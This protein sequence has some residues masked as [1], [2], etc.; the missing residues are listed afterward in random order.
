MPGAGGSTALTR[1]IRSAPDGYTI[2]IGNSG[3]NAATYTIHKDLPFTPDSFT[4][5]G[6]VARTA[7]LIAVKKDSPYRDAAALIAFA[8][9]NPGKLNFGHAGLGSNNYLICKI[10]FQSAGA[11]VTLVSYRGAAP[12][13][14]DLIGGQID[15]VC[16]NATSV[17]GAVQSGQVHGLVV[18]A[19]ARLPKMPGVPTSE[20]AGI[21]AFQAQGWNAVFAPKGIPAA[22][23]DRLRDALR[24]AL[25]GDLLKRRFSEIETAAAAEG[26]LSPEFLR[27]FIPAEIERFKKLLKE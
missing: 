8:K 9:Q 21:P 11:D 5:V 6:I 26:D 10:F 15:G 1:L 13:L 3:T 18:S 7:S 27:T 22:V 4:P 20:E 24:Q 23:E 17:A 16:D 14:Q 25:A 2:A 12:A 19:A